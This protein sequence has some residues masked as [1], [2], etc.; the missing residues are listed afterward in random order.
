MAGTS[1]EYLLPNFQNRPGNK[2]TILI[3]A[4]NF[5]DAFSQDLDL[6]T[7]ADGF[8]LIRGWHIGMVSGQYH[9][10]SF[11]PLNEGVSLGDVRPAQ[12]LK[13]GTAP[14]R[15]D[16]TQALKDKAAAG[17]DVRVFG[18]VNPFGMASAFSEA[19]WF[20]GPA[21]TNAY[22]IASILELRKDAPELAPN[23]CLDFNC[24]A[25]GAT[26]VRLY[27]I[28]NATRAVGYTGGWDL[29]SPHIATQQ[30][31]DDKTTWHDV[32]LRIEGP[33]V[34]DLYDYFRTMWNANLQRPGFGALYNGDKVPSVP[35][36]ATELK[37]RV[38]PVPNQ[39]GDPP[40]GTITMQSV[41]T[42]PK[43]NY[44]SFA[45]S[46]FPNPTPLT[47]NGVTELR[48]A[49]EHAIFQA[50]KYI[51][52]EDQYFWSREVMGWIN[53]RM[54]AV[55]DLKVILLVSG[56]PDPD[57]PD[58]PTHQYRCESLNHSLLK[59]PAGGDVPSA[60]LAS[61]AH[62]FL[63][64]GP[65]VSK[66]YTITV[67][68][69]AGNTQRVTIA[70]SPRDWAGIAKDLFVKLA[71]GGIRVNGLLYKV[72]AN[73]AVPK[74]GSPTLVVTVDLAGNQP[75]AR[76]AIEWV[77]RYGITCHAKTTLI[78]DKW[79]FIGSPNVCRRSLYSDW[80]HSIGLIDTSEALVKDYRKRLWNE[81]FGNSNPDDFEDL[82]ASL[83]SWDPS[84]GTAGSAPGIPT[85]PATEPGVAFLEQVPLPITP[86]KRISVDNQQ[87][88]DAVNDIDARDPWGS[89]CQI[90]RA[91][92]GGPSF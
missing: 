4:Q 23:A 46:R 90:V 8:V 66:N 58:F 22:T 20:A 2:A 67:D 56:R 84:W 10:S 71:P 49:W 72:V 44:A 48:D 87:W 38:L 76:G 32:M 55:P 51:Y 43:E 47:T 34:Q 3:D 19:T 68:P 31:V 7:G 89:I 17:V 14:N 36:D 74:E 16:L 70:T 5:L 42:I 15:K 77:V 78:D 85:P 50:E 60:A 30:H 92:V 27:V 53:Q 12:A 25:G 6:A 26:H 59:D 1:A 82:A 81:H 57:D 80:E 33:S 39:P 91:V 73:D 52:M 61:R 29:F 41:R 13:V 21:E 65:A 9:S 45:C 88:Y 35:K 86:D 64:W 54:V 28:G 75:L 79:A 11:A 18:W 40:L 69:P 63:R 62:L 37:T 24:H 83:H